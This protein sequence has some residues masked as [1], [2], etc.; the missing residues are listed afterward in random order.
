MSDLK[1]LA[2]SRR[3]IRGYKPDP[4]PKEII[5]QMIDIAKCAPSSLNTQ[6]WKI[7]VVTGE[8]L[9][10]IRRESTR[11]ILAGEKPRRDFP[12]KE[13]YEGVYRERQVGVAIQ[14]FE[15]ME[16]ERENRRKRAEWTMRG[17]RLFDA[18]VLPAMIQERSP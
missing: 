17:F 11:R 15:A 1:T 3:S 5:E 10:N 2:E 8:P 14:L 18:D 7:H 6:P 9:E 12:I 13:E 16:I 4:V